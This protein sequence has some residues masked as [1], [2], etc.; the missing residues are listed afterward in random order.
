MSICIILI[1]IIYRQLFVKREHLINIKRDNASPIEFN[2]FIDGKQIKM[3]IVCRGLNT[4]GYIEL[5]AINTGQFD[6]IEKQVTLQQD[7]RDIKIQMFT[8]PYF[9]LTTDNKLKVAYF[10]NLKN[11]INDNNGTDRMLTDYSPFLCINPFD[12]DEFAPEMSKIKLYLGSINEVYVTKSNNQIVNIIGFNPKDKVKYRLKD[13]HIHKIIK[14]IKSTVCHDSNFECSS[15]S[16]NI[17]SCKFIEPL[18]KV[19]RKIK[20]DKLDYTYIEEKSS[21]LDMTSDPI[22]PISNSWNVKYTSVILDKLN[23]AVDADFNVYLSTS[24][25]NKDNL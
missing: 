20:N 9:T 12:F 3:T 21:K 11:F 25:N 1:Y 4:H 17:H 5:S 10:R 24:D 23:I 18:K 8:V 2:R 22:K 13:N 15:L 14:I 16:E 19:S 6:M 7:V